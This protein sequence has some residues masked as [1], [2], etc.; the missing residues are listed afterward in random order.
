MYDL[1]KAARNLEKKASRMPQDERNQPDP[2]VDAPPPPPPVLEPVVD[3]EVRI[4]VEAFLFQVVPGDPLP[5]LHLPGTEAKGGQCLSCGEGETV[6]PNRIRC[7][8][9][10]EA[11][12]LVVEKARP[13]RTEEVK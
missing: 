2:C 8:P 1:A 13:R 11:A 5:F 10:V 3:E 12:R 9:C 4:R 7:R 6:P